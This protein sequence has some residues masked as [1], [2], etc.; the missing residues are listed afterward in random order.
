MMQALLLDAGIESMVRR[1][2]GFDNP[3]FL[4]GGPHEVVVDSDLAA[5]ARG[6]LEGTMLESEDEARADE[7]A[8]ERPSAKAT[9]PQRLALYV[10]VAFL[11]AVLIVW[12]LYELS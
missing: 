9:P 7:M 4:A 1:G 6:V 2:R 11:V 8:L 5:K 10:L 3:D 12:V